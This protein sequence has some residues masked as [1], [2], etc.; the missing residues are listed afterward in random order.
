M[1]RTHTF[2]ITIAPLRC[3]GGYPIFRSTTL[4]EM[5]AEIT[6]HLQN[7]WP[8]SVHVRER[9]DDLMSTNEEDSR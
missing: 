1:K 2:I 3:E 9:S 5:A 8:C 4:D 6:E 7:C